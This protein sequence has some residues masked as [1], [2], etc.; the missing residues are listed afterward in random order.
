MKRKQEFATLIGSRS[1]VWRAINA[2]RV[3]RSTSKGQVIVY[4]KGS[5]ERV[6]IKKCSKS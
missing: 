3:M 5:M 1:I 6:S 4:D 2:I